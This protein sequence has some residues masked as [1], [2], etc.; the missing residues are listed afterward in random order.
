MESSISP[1]QYSNQQYSNINQGQGYQQFSTPQMPQSVQRRNQIVP[2][3]N[4]PN[5]SIVDTS[6]YF[7]QYRALLSQFKANVDC[8]IISSKKGGDTLTLT[9]AGAEKICRYF[10]LNYS[11]ISLPETRLDF[12]NNIF[13]YAYECQL[14]HGGCVVGNGFGNCN[15]RESKYVKAYSPD[16]LQTLDRMAQKRSLVGAVL[17]TTGGSAFFGQKIHD[18]DV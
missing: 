8:R 3:L 17:F 9:K 16:I 4:T 15:N 14:S 5:L 2:L 12:E 13:Y 7:Q 11:L 1:G 18:L 10:G 6:A